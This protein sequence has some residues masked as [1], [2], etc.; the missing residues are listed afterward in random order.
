MNGNLG[1]KG[2][3]NMWQWLWNGSLWQ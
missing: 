2:V 1:K 3:D